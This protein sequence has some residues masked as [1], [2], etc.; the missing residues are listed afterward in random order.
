M[1]AKTGVGTQQ[2][3]MGHVR[4]IQ[5]MI[6]LSFYTRDGAA[7]VV[8]HQAGGAPDPLPRKGPPNSTEDDSAYQGPGIK[9]SRATGQTHQLTN[10]IKIMQWNSEGVMKK[11]LELQHFLQKEKIDV[12]CIQETHLNDSNRFSIRGFECFRQDRLGHK[13]GIIT[14]VRNN[15]PATEIARCQEES[16]HL[17]IK[18]H[19]TPEPLVI[20]NLYCPNNKRLNLRKIP[21]A[22]S[23]HIIVGDFNSHSPSWGYPTM[24]SRGEEIEDWMIENRL[25]LI[26]EPQAEPTFYSR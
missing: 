9:Q 2:W 15:I 6:M 26:N 8:H 10:S 23:N 3:K 11:K 17:T 18:I 19:T 22:E 4:I 16:E 12:L 24:D 1:S 14:M 13:G 25:V 20:T 5:L 7:T 21:L